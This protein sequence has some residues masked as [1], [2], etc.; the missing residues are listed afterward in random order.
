RA[1]MERSL[2]V[3]RVTS[4]VPLLKD[5]S[6]TLKALG[7]SKV[8]DRPALGVQVS[9]TGHPDVSLYFDRD[10]GLLVK[11]AYP[12]RDPATNKDALHEIYFSDFREPDLSAP[13][14]Q[15]L[16]NAGLAVTGPAL[17]E[18]LKHQTPGADRD[19]IKALIRQLGDDS[20]EVRQKAS[21]DL[22]ALGS[23][24]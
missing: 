23:A 13:D 18:F 6:F 17:L 21:D 2:Y 22:V 24:A 11:Y 15:A 20:F 10:N 1:S 16:K 5:K 12:D 14:E 3:D 9:S 8:E 7:E 19:R 4:L